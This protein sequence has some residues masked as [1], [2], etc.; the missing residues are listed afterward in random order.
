MVIMFTTMLSFANESSLFKIKNEATRT[1]LTLLNVKQ[2]NLLSVKD[3]NGIVLYK[4]FMQK[5]G[6]YT[7]GFDLTALPD[8]N[9]IFELEKDLEINT[10]PFTV[11]SNTVLFDKEKETTVFKPMFIVKDD[12]VMVSKLDLKEE[13]VNIKIYFLGNYSEELMHSESI[14]NT[15]AIH[16][17]YKLTGLK[18]GGY[19]IVCQFG[20]KEFTKIINI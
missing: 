11:N 8:G 4:E 7:K 9:Y 3:V 17:A 15:K 6:N 1:S 14:E 12:M 5:S 18:Y 19:R 13:P 16:K 20:G 2:G 10:I